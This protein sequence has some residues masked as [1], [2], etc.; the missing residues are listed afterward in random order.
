MASPSASPAPRAE[1]EKA[2]APKASKES[3]G[4]GEKKPARA[5]SAGS[6]TSR[7]RERGA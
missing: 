6:R 1:G 3:G 5:P 2:A 7:G 4:G